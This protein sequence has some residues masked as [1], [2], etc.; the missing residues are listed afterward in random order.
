[1]GGQDTSVDPFRTLGLIN[2]GDA[3]RYRKSWSLHHCMSHCSR[4]QAG[5]PVGQDLEWGRDLKREARSWISLNS[6]NTVESKRSVRIIDR[7]G[8]I[9]L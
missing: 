8:A 5:H 6:V 9:P 4:D 7:K 3:E 1:M 2:C